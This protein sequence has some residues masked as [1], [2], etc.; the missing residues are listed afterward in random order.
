MQI[1]AV[2]FILSYISGR[3]SV[4]TLP[5]YSSNMRV[6]T[7]NTETIAML[8][9]PPPL[10]TLSDALIDRVVTIIIIIFFNDKLTIATHYKT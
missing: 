10:L 9:D 5:R 4:K 2:V 1:H 3:D 8:K 6:S 7:S